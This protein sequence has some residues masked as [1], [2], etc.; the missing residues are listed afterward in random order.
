MA[1][2]PTTANLL[3]M[4]VQATPPWVHWVLLS[5]CGLVGLLLAVFIIGWIAPKAKK[6][7]T[8]SIER[9]QHHKLVLPTHLDPQAPRPVVLPLPCT[10]TVVEEVP[11]A[12]Q[13]EPSIEEEADKSQEAIQDESEISRNTVEP[14]DEDDDDDDDDDRSE[15]HL[16]GIAT[17][18]AAEADERMTRLFSDLEGSCS[19][20]WSTSSA[21]ISSS[22][23]LYGDFGRGDDSALASFA[24][25]QLSAHVT[26]IQ[27][28]MDV[29]LSTHLE[30]EEFAS[31][32]ESD[33][34]NTPT[35]SPT[36]D[37]D[38]DSDDFSMRTPPIHNG[39]SLV[40]SHSIGLTDEALGEFYGSLPTSAAFSGS[41]C[42]ACSD[43]DSASNYGSSTDSVV[44]I[45]PQ[46]DDD[47]A[48]DMEIPIIALPDEFDVDDDYYYDGPSLVST[49]S[50]AALYELGM[51][52]Y[53]TRDPPLVPCA[54]IPIN[55]APTLPS[56]CY[57]FV[58][59]LAQMNT[60]TTPHHP[61]LY[62][63]K[64]QNRL[65]CHA[66]GSR[67]LVNSSI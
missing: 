33:S 67:L 25:R 19:T 32:D 24:F 30:E 8:A 13:K 21:S 34:V 59:L 40:S 61:P 57:L 54:P 48:Y 51:S 9:A 22:M 7:I 65:T 38:S 42:Y 44:F 64:T 56:N 58:P 43:V 18:T 3:D 12:E 31:F 2:V 20:I 46:C 35:L 28:Q 66:S 1:P 6:C 45:D 14:E 16:D 39:S 53:A 50:T 15:A 26:I 5:I 55:F 23:N 27:P 36:V 11:A 29:D 37:S 41:L 47:M 52:S 60:S 17:E 10:L 49:A 62:L 4:P 63:M